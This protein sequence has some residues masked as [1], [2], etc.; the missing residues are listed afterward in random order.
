MS[1]QL[2]D[3]LAALSSLRAEGEMTPAGMSAALVMLAHELDARVEDPAEAQR[4]FDDILDRM[5]LTWRAK[6]RALSV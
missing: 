3:F 2:D 6:T 4:V 1:R 5:C